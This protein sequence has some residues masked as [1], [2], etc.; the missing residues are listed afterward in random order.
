MPDEER[1]VLEL[2]RER[3]EPA[4]VEAGAQTRRVR[5]YSVRSAGGAA[6]SG[7]QAAPESVVDDLLEWLTLPMHLLCDHAG[8]VGIERQRGSH[9]V[10][11]MPRYGAVKM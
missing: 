11:M 3:V 7:T 10:I 8:D 1:P 4:R 5:P 2:V 6:G 9:V